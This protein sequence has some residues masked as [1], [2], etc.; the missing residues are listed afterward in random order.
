MSQGKRSRRKEKVMPM[1]EW[2][3]VGKGTEEATTEADE[4]TGPAAL[5]PGVSILKRVGSHLFPWDCPP[6]LEAGH[7]H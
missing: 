4:M 3:G 1:E 2:V 6:G 5:Q 7:C